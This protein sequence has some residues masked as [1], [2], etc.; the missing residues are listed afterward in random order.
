MKKDPIT[1]YLSTSLSGYALAN[2]LLNDYCRVVAKLE[3]TK[4]EKVKERIQ[5]EQK[6]FFDDIRNQIINYDSKHSK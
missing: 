6:K 1:I 3:G 2:A 4:P 5:K